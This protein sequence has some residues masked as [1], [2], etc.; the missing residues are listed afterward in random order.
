MVLHSH[1]A[2]SMFNY[3]WE[4]GKMGLLQFAKFTNT[5]WNAAKFDDPYAEWTLFKTY[6]ALIDARE[7]IKVIK[8]QLTLQFTHHQ[9]VEIRLSSSSDPMQC[10]LRFSTPFGYMGA[11]LLA[12]V[13]YVVRQILTLERVGVLLEP[14]NI[15]VKQI[16]QFI[17]QV[18]DIPRSWHPTEITRKDVLENNEKYQQAKTQLGELPDDVLHQKIDFSFL[19]KK[20]VN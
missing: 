16:A 11:Y 12:D 7:K 2:K 3:A 5:M 20:M 6:Q 8:K 1:V 18:F 4:Q 17:Q 10:A 13:D 19:P 15:S 14:E 9:G